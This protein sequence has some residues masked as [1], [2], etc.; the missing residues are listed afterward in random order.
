MSS[1][2]DGSG[3]RRVNSPPAR[4]LVPKLEASRAPDLPPGVT[5]SSSAVAASPTKWQLIGALYHWT[6]CLFIVVLVAAQFLSFFWDSVSSTGN[7]LF[8]RYPIAGA[9][10]EIVGTNDKPVTDRLLACVLEGRFY[11][12]VLLNDVLDTEGATVIPASTEPQ[13]NGYRVVRR[14]EVEALS[15]DAYATY[16]DTCSLLASTMDSILDTCDQQLGYNVTRDELRIVV[17][18]EKANGSSSDTVQVITDSL[19]IVVMPYWDNAP[20]ARYA[21][22]GWDG[23][24]CMFRLTG[25]YIDA[26]QTDSF[27]SMLAVNRS[28]REAKTREWLDAPDGKWR[29]GW[30]HVGTGTE[31]DAAYF[32]DVISTDPQSNVGLSHRE[33]NTVT[34]TE[35]DCV[36]EPDTCLDAPIGQMWGEKL[37]FEE[38][39][40]TM[41]SITIATAQH[42]GFFL[43]DSHY[44]STVRSVYDW[45]T[46]IANVALALL[47]LRWIVAMLAL[48]RGF[49]QGRSGWHSGGLGCV[50]G[51]RSFNLLPIVLLP[52]LKVTLAAFW[53]AGCLFE[54]D[55]S[56]LSES[57]FTVYPA[58]AEFTLV[59]YSILNIATKIGRR[60]ITDALFAPTLALLCLLHRCRGALASSGWLPGVDGRVTTRV[61]SAEL[62]DLRLVDFFISSVGPRLDANLVLLMVLKLVLLAVNLLPLAFATYIP[63]AKQPDTG[64]KGVERA[65]A[66]RASNVGGLGCSPVYLFQSPDGGK[67][68]EPKPEPVKVALNSYEL[69]RLGYVVYGGRFLLTFDA[70]DV[71]FNTAPLRRVQ[72]LWNYRVVLFPL[73]DQDG[74]AAVSEKPVVCRLDDVRLDGIP[75]WSIAAQPVKC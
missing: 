16:S 36:N 44:R 18:G 15:S 51:S 28:V 31:A 12:P 9:M 3:L 71:I 70:W 47:L 1:S 29:H 2:D 75:F 4:E 32:S 8:G 61:G 64:L 66:I 26:S 69:V 54:G 5:S 49:W 59:F 38:Q 58:L 11:K 67:P 63:P 6:T 33:F 43:Y 53:T 34:K 25:K 37:S 21:V 10:M 56:A 20:F 35:L 48:H 55:Q 72:H 68:G 24:A 7:V 17:D 74:Y 65:L 60:R 46:L 23:S 27:P 62:Q 19:P 30:L 39:I 41:T 73:R 57:W 50:A 42:T 52:H 22:P 13:V 40:L 14:R 45:E